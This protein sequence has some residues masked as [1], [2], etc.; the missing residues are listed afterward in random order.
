MNFP[1]RGLEG[2]VSDSVIYLERFIGIFGG[3]RAKS[4]VVQVV[5]LLVHSIGSLQDVLLPFNSVCFTLNSKY[6]FFVLL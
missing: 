5:C 6:V 4:L 2:D 3:E 1:G